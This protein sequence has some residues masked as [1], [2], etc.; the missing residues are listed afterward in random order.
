MY[1]SKCFDFSEGVFNRKV[2]IYTIT[3]LLTKQISSTLY[4]NKHIEFLALDQNRKSGL[5]SVF[6]KAMDTFG[7]I[8]FIVNSTIND[9]MEVN[10]KEVNP[11]ALSISK[12]GLLATKYMG[13]HNGY[14]GGT[15]L[16]VSN[17]Y[18]QQV[19]EKSGLAKSLA[20]D[21][22]K[23]CTIYKPSMDYPDGEVQITDDQH[24]P[25]NQINK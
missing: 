5:D 7:E 15:L 12:M 18:N 24:S 6:L 21:G 11:E 14:Q 16:N 17:S 19:N 13:K 25:Y 10:K 4:G 20:L 1:F 3:I 23:I 2:H 9:S 8:S 22:V